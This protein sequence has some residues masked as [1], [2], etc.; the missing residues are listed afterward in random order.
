[1]SKAIIFLLLMFFFGANLQATHILKQGR[2]HKQ[3]TNA[4]EIHLN[5]AT[6]TPI[7]IKF[8]SDKQPK[9]QRLTVQLMQWY[10]LK[11]PYGFELI[12]TSTDK[13][14]FIHYK[15]RQTYQGYPIK[16]KVVNIHTFKDAVV[17]V[18]GEIV[19]KLNDRFSYQLNFL[20]ALQIA[21]KHIGATAYKWELAH[22]EFH[23]TKRSQKKSTTYFPT[24]KLILIEDKKGV[25][26]LCYEIDV[27]AHQ[28]ESRNLVFINATTGKIETT[29]NLI[30]S[31]SVVAEI[32]TKNSGNR[33]VIV[34]DS[35]VAGK[36]ALIDLTRGNGIG[37][38]D[39][40]DLS[41]I[42]DDD[43]SWTLQ[44]YDNAT[45]DYT[46][47]DCHWGIAATYDYFLDRHNRN[48]FDNNGALIECRVHQ[49]YNN[50]NTNN[51][52][53]T[54]GY[55]TF[56]DGLSYSNTFAA[57]DI[58]AHEF[59]HAI[60]DFTAD[61][62]YAGESGALNES[63]SD[64]FGVVVE[65]YAKP[66]H[67]NGN[68][69]IGED[70]GFILRNL[71]Y[72]NGERHPDTYGSNDPYWVEIDGCWPADGNDLCGVHINSGVQN[73]WFYLLANGGNGT[74]NNGATYKVTGI[75]I[76]KAAEIAYRSLTVYL[77]PNS[78]YNDA[79]RYSIESAKDLFG[80]CPASQEL[81]S[82]INAWAAVGLGDAYNAANQLQPQVNILGP[83]KYCSVPQTI[84]FVA[85]SNFSNIAYSWN[86]EDSTTTTGD[87]VSHTFTKAG[88]YTIALQA[89]GCNA[90]STKT[91]T[92]LIVIDTIT[93]CILT[94]PFNYKAT[95]TVCSGTLYDT[96]GP[97]KS[98]SDLSDG[99]VTIVAPLNES[100]KLL[101]TEF[102]YEI[103]YD[104]LYIHDGIDTSANL[105]ATLNGYNLPD[106]ISS[107][108]NS[109]TIRHSSDLYVVDA[110]FTLNWWSDSCEPSAIKTCPNEQIFIDNSIA[111]SGSINAQ[112]FIQSNQIVT[113]NNELNYV[114]GD[115]IILSNEFEVK[116]D[117][118][119]L[120]NIE[121]C[122]E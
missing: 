33:S 116:K 91:E 59:T 15:F 52:T 42:T 58:V 45:R 105:I 97:G 65:F 53:W 26:Q 66:P 112:S 119:F 32:E 44:E 1:M 96:N 76:E 27:F 108:G 99:T 25:Y 38:I 14:G 56:G 70:V 63:F 101:F 121:I 113:N 17:S 18:N 31:N 104:Y 20:N 86:F 41:I 80:E 60:T 6:Q 109:I 22:E 10:Q 12:A 71:S 75:G 8:E 103:D 122:V 37:I 73:Y 68:W 100:I 120:A 83:T 111:N 16:N 24:N 57:L 84:S 46:A 88:S 117:A 55:L 95:E 85:T 94:M 43:N 5:K 115:S 9:L 19:N 106:T 28:P 2:A 118:N 67:K 79:K 36:Y 40:R 4:K 13:L 72:P 51:A 11:T 62:V 93:P 30:C 87:T 39:S 107:T 92:D 69:L 50:G 102:G 23:L 114:A 81:I 49:T 29:E 47:L 110:G 78:N 89:A 3:V 90:T 7:F 82:T 48:S 98:Y 74:N 61:L 35:I 54:G 64:I 21:K 34:N 77:T